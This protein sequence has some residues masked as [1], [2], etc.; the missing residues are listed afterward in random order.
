M[1]CGFPL[2]LSAVA[3]QILDLPALDPPVSWEGAEADTELMMLLWEKRYPGGQVS[4]L[5][6]C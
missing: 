6:P 5:P 4:S 2:A 3:G 1:R